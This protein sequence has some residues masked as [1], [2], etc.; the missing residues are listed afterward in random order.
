ME[1]LSERSRSSF[2]HRLGGLHATPLGVSP[3]G[4]SGV[5]VPVQMFPMSTV[6]GN[7][8]PHPRS[9]EVTALVGR[10]D[11][12]TKRASRKGGPQQRLYLSDT[13]I[14]MR[15]TKARDW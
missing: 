14:K 8:R 7:Q 13:P 5:E 9:T 11:P 4:S 1:A 10:F 12:T 3:E 2:I 6:L 15:P